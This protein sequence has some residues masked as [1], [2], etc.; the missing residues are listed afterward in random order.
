MVADHGDTWH[1]TF[2]VQQSGAVRGHRERSAAWIAGQMRWL[3]PVLARVGKL[4]EAAIA[5]LP[6]QQMP[7]GMKSR[8]EGGRDEVWRRIFIFV[9]E[10]YIGGLRANDLVFVLAV[11]GDRTRGV[12]AAGLAFCEEQPVDRKSTRLNSSHLG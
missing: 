10:L 2:P 11:F 3:I 6:D 7:V 12:R 5:V 9:G 4:L 8:W 1:S